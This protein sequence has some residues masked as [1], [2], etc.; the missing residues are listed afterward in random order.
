MTRHRH[1]WSNPRFLGDHRWEMS[2]T[3]GATTTGT[4][5]AEGTRADAAALGMPWKVYQAWLEAQAQARALVE[6]D[7]TT[8]PI[9]GPG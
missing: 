4:A 8:W 3:C 9:G 5:T 1:R 6:L 7:Q 2:C